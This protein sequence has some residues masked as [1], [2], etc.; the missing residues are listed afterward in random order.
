MNSLDRRRENDRNSK[1]RRRY[2]MAPKVPCFRCLGKHP[3]GERNCPLAAEYE[4]VPELE[5]RW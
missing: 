3:S 1:R 5:E 2:A 4:S